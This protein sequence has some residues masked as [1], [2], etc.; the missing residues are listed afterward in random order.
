[1][2]WDLIALGETMVVFTPPPGESMR[3][4]TQ[5][6]VDHAGAESNTCVGLARLGF[7]VA[8]VSRVG[9][10]RAGDRI[11]DAMTA[12]GVDTRWVRRDPTRP[13]GLMLKERDGVRYYRSGSAASAMTTADLD[14]VELPEAR[15]VLVTGVTAL[16]G[17]GAHEAGRT[18]LSRASGLRIVDPNLRDGLWG[19]A[20]RAELVTVFMERC[21]LVLGGAAELREL[22]AGSDDHDVARRAAARGPRE[23]VVRGQQSVG[24]LCESVWRT[25][26][27]SRGDAVDPVGAGDAFNAGYIA[28]RLRGGSVEEAL[29]AGVRCGRAVTTAP[30]DTAAF[31]R[32]L[33]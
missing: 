4:A 31:P 29:H 24:A 25:A 6:A 15:A 17:P 21:D 32:S 19:S 33:G 2:T 13:T 8:W 7:R 30:S 1:M 11:L 27:I 5:V 20:R 12:E 28:V 23:V 22:L 14:G 9:G 18:L 3:T 10:D 16:I 26:P